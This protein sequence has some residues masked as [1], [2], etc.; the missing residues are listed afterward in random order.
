MAMTGQYAATPTRSAATRG[1][2]SSNSTKMWWIIAGT[3]VALA[4]IAAV[5]LFFVIGNDSSNGSGGKGTDT[6]QSTTSQAPTSS[7][8][9][10]APTE[11]NSAID[12]G[13][14][15]G[16]IQ[17]AG[18]YYPFQFTLGTD[19][20]WE[21]LKSE[22]DRSEFIISGS[23]SKP[24]SVVKVTVVAEPLTASNVDAQLKEQASETGSPTTL[25]DY[26]PVVYNTSKDGN[27]VLW[28]YTNTMQGADRHGFLY[29]VL[30]EGNVLWKFIVG[31]PESET[32]K[33]A[34]TTQQIQN[35]AQV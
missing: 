2:T 21:V 33:T 28:E 32:E 24:T 27:A 23:D 16:A 3:L 8:E 10:A 6:T 13:V 11:N 17:V 20:S 5:V 9:P 19:A 22:P 15:S 30:G 29:A 4:A 12:G 34:Q 26:S 35:S 1:G 14:A 7:S 31:G 18:T 25:T